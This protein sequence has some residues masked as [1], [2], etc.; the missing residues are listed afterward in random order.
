MLCVSRQCRQLARTRDPGEVVRGM[1]HDRRA[2]AGA[3]AATDDRIDPIL[4]QAL[5][6]HS[7][8]ILPATADGELRALLAVSSPQVNGFP[9]AIVHGLERIRDELAVLVA[10]ADV[11][12]PP[13]DRQSLNDTAPQHA[14]AAVMTV[15]LAAPEGEGRPVLLRVATVLALWAVLLAAGILGLYRWRASKLLPAATLHPFG[16]VQPPPPTTSDVA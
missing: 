4:A 9:A 8:V 12:H 14:P 15:A 11:A 13:Q 7:A 2:S 10:D 16:Y 6:M 3:D 5:N 1:P